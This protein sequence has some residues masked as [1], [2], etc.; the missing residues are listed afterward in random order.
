MH[1]GLHTGDCG[2]KL[3]PAAPSSYYLKNN[4]LTYLFIDTQS[5]KCSVDGNSKHPYQSS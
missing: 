1:W 4:L 5:N 3:F 2:L